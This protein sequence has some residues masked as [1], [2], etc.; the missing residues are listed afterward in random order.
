MDF[1]FYSLINHVVMVDGIAEKFSSIQ[2]AFADIIA[3]WFVLVLTELFVNR[4][5][6]IVEMIAERLQIEATANEVQ[7]HRDHTKHVR[8][9]C[10]GLQHPK[11]IP[12]NQRVNVEWRG[13]A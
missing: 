7:K 12:S 2:W 6:E 4:L 10:D 3:F 1:F 5:N 8:Y 9:S 13:D 11:Q